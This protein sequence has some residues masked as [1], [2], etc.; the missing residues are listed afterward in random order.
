MKADSQ[1]RGC[2]TAVRFRSRI[3]LNG[4]NPYVLVSASLATRLKQNWRKS[5]PVRAALS[6]KTDVHWRVNLMPVGDGSFYLYLHG[7]IR[8]A[9]AADVG[10]MVRITAQFDDEYRNGP[11]SPMPSWF[12]RELD[13]NPGAKRGWEGLIPSRQKEIL[14][15]FSGLKSPQAQQ[16]NVHRALQVL[17]GGKARFMAREWNALIDA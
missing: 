9:A 4:I 1:T 10:D 2:I 3:K 6:G 13:R 8:K 16:R 7:A 11:I 14:R 17:A 12:A 5:M 15:Y